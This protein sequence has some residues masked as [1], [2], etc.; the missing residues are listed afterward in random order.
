MGMFWGEFSGR[1]VGLL[2]LGLVARRAKRGWVPIG[3]GF[4]RGFVIEVG[5][6]CV[7]FDA[8][9]FLFGYLVLIQGVCASI[10]DLIVYLRSLGDRRECRFRLLRVWSAIYAFYA[11]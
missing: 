2:V 3:L 11:S 9:L 1:G 10:S 7:R 6:G 4:W 5:S 8:C